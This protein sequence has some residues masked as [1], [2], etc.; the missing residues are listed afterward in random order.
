MSREEIRVYLLLI[1]QQ[2]STVPTT[3]FLEQKKNKE[4]SGAYFYKF[5]T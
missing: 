3:G 4:K 2:I 5:L 1:G